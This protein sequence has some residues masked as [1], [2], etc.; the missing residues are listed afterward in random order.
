MT[1]RELREARAKLVEEARQILGKA[2]EE[3]RSMTAE[4]DAKWT[5]IHTDVDRLKTQIDT[6]ERQAAAE[7]DLRSNPAPDEKKL[8]TPAFGADEKRRAFRAWAAQGSN[9]SLSAE[10]LELA[11]KHGFGGNSITIYVTVPGGPTPQAT[12]QATVDALE[13]QLAEIFGRLAE[14]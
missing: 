10:D 14:Q 13:D 1:T 5:A 7:A 9:V 4:E 2:S 6:L 3:K 11:R 8:V 12:A